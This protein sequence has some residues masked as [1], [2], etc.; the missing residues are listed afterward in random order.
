[1]LSYLAIVEHRQKKKY[2][3]I[4]T[5]L[6]D[7]FVLNKVKTMTY[8]YMQIEFESLFNLKEIKHFNKCPTIC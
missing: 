6:Q 5:I 1:M 4:Y 3:Y 7:L 8:V 2:I